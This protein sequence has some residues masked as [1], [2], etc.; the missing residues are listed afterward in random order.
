MEL[1]LGFVSFN[2][3]SW[4]PHSS[5]HPESGKTSLRNARAMDGNT[6]I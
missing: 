5:Q 4:S 1:G 3:T 6:R 2:V